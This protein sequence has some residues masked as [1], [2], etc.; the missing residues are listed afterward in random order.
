MAID[1]F[2]LYSIDLFSEMYYNYK[3]K[4]YVYFT[5]MFS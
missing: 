3:Q 4:F 2:Y 1:W 5:V